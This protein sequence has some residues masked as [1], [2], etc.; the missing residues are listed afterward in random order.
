[1]QLSIAGLEALSIIAYKQPI[2]KSD[3]EYIRG[4][5]CDS[6]IKTLLAKDLVTIKGREE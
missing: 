4:V 3:V 6:M 5:N 1:M 2:S